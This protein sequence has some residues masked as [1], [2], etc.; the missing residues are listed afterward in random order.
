M[1]TNQEAK[2]MQRLMKETFNK[3]VSFYWNKD[4]SKIIFEDKNE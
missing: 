4:S 1:I 2:A 3:K